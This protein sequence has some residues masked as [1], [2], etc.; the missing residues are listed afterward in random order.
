M[1]GD[2]V[3]A[4][5]IEYLTPDLMPCAEEFHITAGEN[6]WFGVP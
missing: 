4:K 1:D 2:A 5:Y 3:M 6:T